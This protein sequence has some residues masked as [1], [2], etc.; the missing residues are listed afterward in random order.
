MGVSKFLT[1]SKFNRG[2][3]AVVTASSSRL[4]TELASP[5]ACVPSGNGMRVSSLIER[6]VMTHFIKMSRRT[7]LQA[8]IT[9]PALS[10][11]RHQVAVPSPD[12]IARDEIIEVNGWILKR[13]DLA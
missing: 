1:L 3:C 10:L 11:F 4:G 7:I 9:L 12:E 5:A 13:S 8:L 2:D 6:R